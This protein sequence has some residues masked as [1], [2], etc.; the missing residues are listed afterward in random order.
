MTICGPD[1]AAMSARGRSGLRWSTRS[2]GTTA[3]TRRPTGCRSRRTVGFRRRRRRRPLAWVAPR[4][5]AAGIEPRGAPRGRRAAGEV[6]ADRS[7]CV[8]GGTCSSARLLGRPGGDLLRARRGTASQQP[9]PQ[10]LAG[11]GQWLTRLPF[12]AARTGSGWRAR[13]AGPARMARGVRG[14]DRGGPHRNPVPGAG[15]ACPVG[16][17]G[18]QDSHVGRPFNACRAR[19][20]RRLT[21][22]LPTC[23]SLGTGHPPCSRAGR[24]GRTLPAGRTDH[25]RPRAVRLIVRVQMMAFSVSDLRLSAV[26]L[27]VTVGEIVRRVD[28]GCPRGG[29][30]RASP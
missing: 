28:L 24:A 11:R 17:D 15:A 22:R 18:R 16:G 6:R 10:R 14:P 19:S 25:P 1:P 3:G 9:L 2:A 20:G 21:L 5:V 26:D 4:S 12:C 8:S 23:L 30:R 7:A 27:E 29:A 13:S